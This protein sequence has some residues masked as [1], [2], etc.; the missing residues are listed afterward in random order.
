MTAKAKSYANALNPSYTQYHQNYG[1]SGAQYSDGRRF[2]TYQSEMPS[3]V[4]HDGGQ[5]YPVNYQVP[6]SMPAPSSHI[7]TFHP[8]PPAHGYAP[9]GD[10]KAASGMGYGDAYYNQ[11]QPGYGPAGSYPQGYNQQ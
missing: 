11:P 3:M 5:Q 7:P 2:Q 10:Q 1:P 4:P 8:Q 9:F 6:P